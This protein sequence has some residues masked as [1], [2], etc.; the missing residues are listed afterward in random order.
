MRIHLHRLLHPSLQVQY[1]TNDDGRLK[2]ASRAVLSFVGTGEWSRSS[3]A[4][5]FASRGTYTLERPFST[6]FLSALVSI[7]R[8]T[9]YH[10]PLLRALGAPHIVVA[11]L[12]ILMLYPFEITQE[13]ILVLSL[14]TVCGCN[15]LL[16]NTTVYLL[17]KG[18]RTPMT[19]QDFC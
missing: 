17:P 11:R 12:C 13:K 15:K 1:V 19:Y 4:D 18:D 14:D 8:T 2:G 3:F 5:Y 16:V 10:V 9:H 7:I 6:L